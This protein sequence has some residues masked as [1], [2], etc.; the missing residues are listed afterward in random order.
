MLLSIFLKRKIQW[1]AWRCWCSTYQAD[2]SAV[3]CVQAPVTAAPISLAPQWGKHSIDKISHC[4]G[5]K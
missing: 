5:I 1:N 4:V 3:A 2:V